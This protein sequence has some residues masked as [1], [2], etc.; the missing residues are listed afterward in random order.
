MFAAGAGPGSGAERKRTVDLGGAVKLID[1]ARD[2]GVARYVMVSAM[3]TQ[4][5]E[6]AADAMRPYLQAKKDADD[7]LMASGLDWTIVRPGRLTDA[8]GRGPSTPRGRSA[9]AARSPA[10]TRRSCCWRRSC[11]RASPGWPSTC[12]RARCWWG[13]RWTALN[14]TAAGGEVRDPKGPSR[15]SCPRVQVPLYGKRR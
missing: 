1:A 7:A 12:S 5:V 13:R 10:T 6:H 8:P 2:L 11:A 14:V 3:G 4:D 9:A 15:V